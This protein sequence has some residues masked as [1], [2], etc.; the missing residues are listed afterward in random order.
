MWTSRCA[1]CDELKDL[2]VSTVFTIVGAGPAEKTLKALA[3]ALG[4]TDAVRWVPW[5]PQSELHEHYYEHDVLLFPSLRDSGG[6]VVLEALAHGLPVVCADVGGP[7]VIVNERCG[8]VVRTAGLTRDEIVAAL[9]R[10]L[11]ELSCDRVLLNKLGRAA[12]TRAWE[13]DFHKVVTQL[14]P[15][16]T[17]R[18]TPVSSAAQANVQFESFAVA[19]ETTGAGDRKL[20]PRICQALM[21]LPLFSL[22]LLPEYVQG[23]GDPETK[24]VLYTRNGGALAND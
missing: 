24:S 17:D 19:L 8:R 11:L 18:G 23:V 16:M 9:A 15:A 20:A 4:V 7:G 10:V 14:H 21:L 3:A 13:F 2:G 12:R 1:P 5:A 6:M 22:I